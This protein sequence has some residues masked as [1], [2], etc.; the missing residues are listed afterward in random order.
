MRYYLD[1]LINPLTVNSVCLNSLLGKYAMSNKI[2]QS[3]TQ[4]ANLATNN[5]IPQSGINEQ[6]I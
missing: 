1:F 6:I 5:Q 2:P 4:V 3:G